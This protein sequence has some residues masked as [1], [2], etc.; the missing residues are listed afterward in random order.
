MNVLFRNQSAM[1]FY[2]LEGIQLAQGLI[3]QHL[4]TSLHC[5]LH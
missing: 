1:E 4:D 2:L 3:K 5:I